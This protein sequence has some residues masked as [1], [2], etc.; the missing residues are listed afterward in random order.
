LLITSLAVSD[1]P[2]AGFNIVLTSLLFE[3]FT[4]GGLYVLTKSQS[5]VAVGFLL[6]VGTMMT[7]MGLM[8]AIYW[9]Q[10]SGCTQILNSIDISSDVI[11][12][13]AC[14]HKG[15]YRAICIFS[16]LLFLLSGGFTGLLAVCKDEL[17]EGNITARYDTIGGVIPPP[18]NGVG[19]DSSFD[20][21]AA[22][23]N[24]GGASNNNTPITADL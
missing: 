8:T 1:T 16:T 24:A 6:G 17:F 21:P 9:G 14:N 18:S 3:L 23:S 7:I 11:S 12:Q 22:P 15:G 19:G 13:Y 2:N 20:R 10:L 5:P 4:L